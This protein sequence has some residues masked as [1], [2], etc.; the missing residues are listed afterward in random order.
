MC[1]RYLRRFLLRMLDKQ[2]AALTSYKL[3]NKSWKFSEMILHFFRV[4]IIFQL[5]T[6]PGR[7]LRV[8][9][10]GV[11]VDDTVTNLSAAAGITRDG[12]MTS[13]TERL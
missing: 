10:E 9:L 2:F 13:T 4:Q 1:P 8:V 12:L 7:S 5:S 11:E 3:Q 6:L